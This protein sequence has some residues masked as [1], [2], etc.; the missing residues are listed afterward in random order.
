[1]ELA[2]GAI[3]KAPWNFITALWIFFLHFLHSRSVFYEYL[4]LR[5]DATRL[6]K[7]VV[8]PP[9]LNCVLFPTISHYSI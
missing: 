7:Q 2:A 9:V 6:I 8:K 4:H 1:M 3:G 5:E